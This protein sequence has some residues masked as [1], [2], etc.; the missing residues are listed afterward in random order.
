[1]FQIG[2]KVFYPMH[3]AGTIKAIEEKEVLGS[4]KEY[5]VIN[6]PISKMDIMIPMDKMQ[7]SGV[8]SV[9]DR[10]TMK[11]I[12]FDFQHMEPHSTL[13]WKERYSSNLEKLK[14]G[15]VLDS[16]EIICDLLFRSKEKALN[17]SEKQ[18]LNQARRNV[19]SELILV[20]DFTEKQAAN[21]LKVSS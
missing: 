18:M 11:D 12:I 1:M 9:V 3:G 7:S 8:R 13:P 19:I 4:K 5:Y 6:I 16:V 14:T 20:A 21:L 17:T 15:D 10:K 2:D